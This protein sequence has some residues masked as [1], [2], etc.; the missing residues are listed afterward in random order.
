MARWRSATVDPVSGLRRPPKTLCPTGFVGRIRSSS[1]LLPLE[2]R[3][4][5]K[6]IGLGVELSVIGHVT[7]RRYGTSPSKE[8]TDTRERVKWRLETGPLCI[9]IPFSAWDRLRMTQRRSQQ[10]VAQKNINAGATYNENQVRIRYQTRKGNATKAP[11]ISERLRDFQDDR[12]KARTNRHTFNRQ[13]PVHDAA[14]ASC[15]HVPLEATRCD[16][17]P[18]MLARVSESH[19]KLPLSLEAYV[20][21]SRTS[22]VPR[23]VKPVHHAR[24]ECL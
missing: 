6:V 14:T 18:S 22:K 5:I 13:E 16:V 1:Y 8:S 11:S 12:G 23:V 2:I 17:D 21:P 9:S 7:L 3:I 4:A 10:L 19:H 20:V 24:M 15:A